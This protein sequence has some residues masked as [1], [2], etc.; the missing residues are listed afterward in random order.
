MN[1]LHNDYLKDEHLED[2][3]EEE[4]H[5]QSEKSMFLGIKLIRGSLPLLMRN[6]RCRLWTIST[7]FRRNRVCL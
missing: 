5:L 2:E 3:D 4:L 6:F 7:V 1:D